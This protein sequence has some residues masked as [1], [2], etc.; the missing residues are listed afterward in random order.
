MSIDWISITLT[1]I[2]ALSSFGIG[3]WVG[4]SGISGIVTDVE[5]LKADLQG[6]KI[7]IMN[8]ATPAPVVVTPVAP[9]A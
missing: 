1:E 5:N 8:G 4:H 7:S 6:V 9:V 3:F 2:L